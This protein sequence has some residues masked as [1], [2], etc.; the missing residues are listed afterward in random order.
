MKS[1]KQ[2]LGIC[3]HKWKVR[4]SHRL[5]EIIEKGYEKPVGMKFVLQCEG[6][7]EIKKKEI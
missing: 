4:S 5:M 3:E 2:L 7:G 1:L 6:C